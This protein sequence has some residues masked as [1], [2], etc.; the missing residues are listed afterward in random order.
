VNA[1]PGVDLHDARHV[2]AGRVGELTRRLVKKASTPEGAVVSTISNGTSP[3]NPPRAKPRRWAD[4]LE[5]DP[6]NFT[7]LLYGGGSIDP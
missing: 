2:R 5:P 4:E 1:I 3:M 7:G 6:L